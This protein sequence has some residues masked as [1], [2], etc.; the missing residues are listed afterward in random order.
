MRTQRL[1]R[2]V[3]A[4]LFL[5]IG[6]AN[7]GCVVLVTRDAASE[8]QPAGGD[9]ATPT[10]ATVAPT[11]EGLPAALRLD[12]HR[13]HMTVQV[14][15]NG[16]PLT[17]MLD[18]GA[19]QC[20]ITADAAR[21]AG[22]A[23]DDARPYTIRD[24]T[25]V[26]QTYF[27]TTAD[28]LRLPAEDGGAGAT[29]RRVDLAV[30]PGA[31]S[32]LGCDG[33]LGLDAMRCGVFTFDAP[34]GRLNITPGELPPEGS[35][36]LTEDRGLLSLPLAGPA[37][38]ILAEVD[39]GNNEALSVGRATAD[40]IGFASGPITVGHSTGLHSRYPTQVGR[41][42]D[43]LAMGP[44]RLVKPVVHL[45]ADPQGKANLGNGLLRRYQWQLDAR[46][47]RMRLLGDTSG[48]YQWWYRDCWGFDYDGDRHA[49]DWLLP[50]GGAAAA[51]MRFGRRGGERRR[52]AGLAEHALAGVGR[53]VP[54]RR[55]PRRPGGSA[56]GQLDAAPLPGVTRT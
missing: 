22:L 44:V 14:E 5:V 21:R 32:L 48:P 25:G 9:Q 31:A 52:R 35:L 55:P 2:L 11:A 36:P 53:G 40:A 29:L 17:F 49:V 12:A 24:I 38:P 43:D 41:L 39:T 7:G 30:I 13:G 16:Q 6:G 27:L 23:P 47:R 46:H 50:S 33:Q 3:L 19:A 37:G 10:P 28:A 8:L 42:R 26:R 54:R 56:D 1:L 51:G 4:A 45:L 34:A 18:S 15:I 20:A